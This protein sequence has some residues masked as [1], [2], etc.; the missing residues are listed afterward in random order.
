MRFFHTLWT[1]PM[2]PAN[3][4]A[5]IVA[6]TASAALIKNFGGKIV[7]HTDYLGADML[8]HI[9]YDEIIVDLNELPV[10]ICNKFW[11]YGK[12]YATSKESLGS[13]HIDGDVFLKQPALMNLFN[14]DYD[15]LV[16]SRE[17]EN[18]R[19]NA[20]YENTQ[21]VY[22]HY[23]LPNN[24]SAVWPMAYNCGIVKINNRTLKKK[25]LDTYFKTV[26]IITED[27]KLDDY[28]SEANARETG[29]V[30]LDIV[31]EQQFLTQIAEEGNY[32]TKFI[33]NGDIFESA[34]KLGYTHLCANS[35]Y[36]LY[37]DMKIM[38]QKIDMHLYNKMC[39]NDIFKTYELKIDY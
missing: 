15:L 10:D 14:D 31:A 23:D 37:D 24:M 22:S 39:D 11:A 6:F 13:V 7:L 9:P 16:Q 3:V 34:V 33:L 20:C 8:S 32:D 12:L 17:D 19:K 4:A 5:N 1:A 27:A 30:I 25:Y 18:W 35:K 28:I 26:D 38:L 21:W 29:N 2:K 36:E